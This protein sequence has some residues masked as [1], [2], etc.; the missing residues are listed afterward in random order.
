MGRFLIWITLLE[1]H[2][3]ARGMASWVEV[4]A[5]KLWGPEC[6]SILPHSAGLS[7]QICSLSAPSEKADAEE[8]PWRIMASLPRIQEGNHK[9]TMSQPKRKVSN[10]CL[11]LT[12]D[13]HKS[14]GLCVHI[15][16]QIHKNSLLIH[17]YAFTCKKYTY[18]YKGKEN[19]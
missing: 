3:E 9:E 12:S 17:T 1:I 10:W 6:D 15:H 4:L 18:S 8:N 16:L 7:V 11:T 2:S 5:T 13:L 19:G 14:Y